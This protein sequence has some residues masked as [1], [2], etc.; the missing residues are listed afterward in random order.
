MTHD[1]LGTRIKEFENI[2]AGKLMPRMPVIIRVDGKSFHTVLSKADKPFDVK[3]NAAMTFV[4]KR[5]ISNIPGTGVAYHQSDECSLL[6]TDWD[7][8]TTQSWFDYKIQ[9]VASVAASIATAAFNKA[10]P[11]RDES[12][13]DAR[14]FNLPRHEVNNYF[15]WRQQDAVRNSINAY[16]QALLPKKSLHGQNTEAVRHRLYDECG[17][18]WTAQ[19]G[20]KRW[21][22]VITKNKIDAEVMVAP[23][24]SEDEK[25]SIRDDINFMNDRNFI[26]AYMTEPFW[27]EKENKE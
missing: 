27:R 14:C 25:L 1:R 10:Y 16:G 22:Q 4:A 7:R 17:I 9:K 20:W 6:L 26:E 19:E 8:Y 21:G 18:I 5:L 12:Y 15:I 24:P 11:E 2:A 13:F 3:V 23:I